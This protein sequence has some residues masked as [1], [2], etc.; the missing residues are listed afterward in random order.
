MFVNFP[1]LKV[2]TRYPGSAVGFL[3]Q[4]PAPLGTKPTSPAYSVFVETCPAMHEVRLPSQF[5]RLHIFQ[6]PSVLLLAILFP[7]CQERCMPSLIAHPTKRWHCLTTFLIL[8][9]W[10]RWALSQITLLL[11]LH[12]AFSTTHP[13]AS[14]STSD[15]LISIICP[16][17]WTNGLALGFV[18]KNSIGS[19]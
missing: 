3:I 12:A 14:A 9:P 19:K 4:W 2:R 17:A 5:R 1:W 13:L 8:P 7:C 11:T 10:M 16:I 6:S 18:C 15:S